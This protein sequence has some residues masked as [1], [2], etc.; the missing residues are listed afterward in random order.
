MGLAGNTPTANVFNGAN[1]LAGVSYDAAGN[2]SSVNGDT[3]TYDAENRQVAATDPPALGGGTENYVYD[4][5]GQR[6]EKSGAA[7][8]AVSVY[9]VLG[10]VV[11]EYGAAG[12]S[13]PCATCYLVW[14]HLGTTRLVTDQN[15]NVIARHDYLPFGEE[16]AAGTAGRSS[17]WG[18]LADN[19]EQKFTGQVRDGET[20]IDYFNAR[21]Y[22]S[23]PVTVSPSSNPNSTG[24]YG[25]GQFGSFGNGFQSTEIGGAI[26]EGCLLNPLACAVGG[27]AIGEVIIWEHSAPGPVQVPAGWHYSGPRFVLQQP[28][29]TLMGKKLDIRQNRDARGRSLARQDADRRTRMT[30]T[31]CT[32]S[33]RTK[34]GRMGR[35][36]MRFFWLPGGRC[37]ASSRGPV[38]ESD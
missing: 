8:T 32:K 1:Q 13:S 38:S 21:Y 10:R 2:Q 14:D 17:Q 6:V 36:V 35:S 25:Q 27:L 30:M 12:A 18:P 7:G 4:G 26:A 31:T 3:M 24:V 15:A 5:A 16:I 28:T 11:A 34:R 37:Y 20:G 29:I 23:V 33:S 9:D 19:I 22:G